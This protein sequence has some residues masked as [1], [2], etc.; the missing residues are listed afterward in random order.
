MTSK[1]S[2]VEKRVILV[3]LNG[4]NASNTQ[5]YLAQ[6]TVSVCKVLHKSQK[7]GFLVLND[8]NVSLLHKVPHVF[9]VFA[10]CEC[11]RRHTCIVSGCHWLLYQTLRRREHLYHPEHLQGHLYRCLG[12]VVLPV[13]G[14]SGRS[15]VW[16]R[17]GPQTKLLKSNTLLHFSTG[18]QPFFI[19]LKV[20]LEESSVLYNYVCRGI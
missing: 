11:L 6:I 5:L 1:E 16:D 18:F 4:V 20:A 13:S 19:L 7:I 8:R 2:F 17:Y 14:W 9:A 3:L 10:R 12:H 15:P